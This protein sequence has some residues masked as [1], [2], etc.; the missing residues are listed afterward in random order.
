M[1]ERYHT[2]VLIAPQQHN[3]LCRTGLR[4]GL[5]CGSMALGSWDVAR[6]AEEVQRQEVWAMTPD[7]L[8]HCLLHAYVKVGGRPA[9]CRSSN[10]SVIWLGIQHVGARSD[11]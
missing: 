11:T 7:V 3:V 8:L 5:Y 1:P 10:V 6:W 2:I 4:C 9:W